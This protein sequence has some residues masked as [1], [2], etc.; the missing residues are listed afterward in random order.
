MNQIEQIAARAIQNRR[1][2]RE[3]IDAQIAE[4]EQLLKRGLIILMRDDYEARD[5]WLNEYRSICKR[6]NEN[7]AELKEAA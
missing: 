3:M 7:L 6:I 1:I 2:T 4:K 5:R